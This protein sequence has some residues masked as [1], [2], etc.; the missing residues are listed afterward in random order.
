MVANIEHGIFKY[1]E[2]EGISQW[3]D[4]STAG[5]VYWSIVLAL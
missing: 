1:L 5:Q 2:F 4:V 3:G